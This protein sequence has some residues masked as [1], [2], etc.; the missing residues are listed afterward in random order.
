MENPRP[1]DV[2]ASHLTR[3]AVGYTRQSTKRQVE[4]NEGSTKHQEAQLQFARA[5][6]WPED[7]IEYVDD[8]LGLSGTTSARRLGLQRIMKEVRADIIGAIFVS[9]L[10]RLGRNVIELLLFLEECRTHDVLIVVNGRVQDLSDDSQMFPQ[11]VNSVV[12]EYENAR[13]RDIMM[14]G[15]QAKAQAGKAVSRPPTGLVRDKDGVW[16]FDPDPALYEAIAAVP[17]TFLRCRSLGRTVRELIRLGVRIPV[18]RKGGLIE[19]LPP[20]VARV[21]RILHNPA[22]KGTYCF[23]QQRVDQNLGRTNAGRPKLRPGTPDDMIVID[24]KHPAYVPPAE[25]DEIQQMLAVNAPSKAR[26]NLGPGTARLQGIIR[27]GDHPDRVMTPSYHKGKT[28]RQESH[29]YNCLGDHHDG[30]H[31]CPSTPG[32]AIDQAVVAAIFARLQVP[33]LRAT[34]AAWEEARAGEQSEDRRRQIEV[35]RATLAVDDAKR[36]ALGVS[37][38]NRTVLNK[39]EALWEQAERHLQRLQAIVAS[40]T[41]PALR[42]TKDAW[43]ELLGLRDELA[44]LWNAPTTTVTDQ[45]ELIR[46]MV[47]MVIVEERTAEH[48]Q[49]RIVWADNEPDTRLDIKRPAY[50]HRLI[51]EWTLQGVEAAEIAAKLN[52][53]GLRTFQGREW[54]K[55]TVQKVIRNART[56]TQPGEEK[57]IA[58]KPST[59]RRM[60]R[61]SGAAAS[62]R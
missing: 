19:W 2:T 45:K 17:R 62:N 12:M 23:G 29:H 21:A 33:T 4:E 53:L 15:R 61:G 52:A 46:T 40:E 51:L 30:G 49:A 27:C 56:K 26:R 59:H 34:E 3:T 24:N 31:G 44:T 47:D 55:E 35:Q 28:A 7:R 20:T 42:F 25:W 11:K 41:S 57:R 8:D 54:S 39:Y 32:K 43:E 14:R 36:R 18:R 16:I 13:R 6:G 1:P 5:W 9:D 37:P 50:C 58:G 22:Y 48:V 38:S 10:S 60:G